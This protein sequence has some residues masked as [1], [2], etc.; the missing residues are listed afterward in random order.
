MMCVLLM[1]SGA[2]FA[3][4]KGKAQVEQTITEEE[5]IRLDYF[6]Y[7]VLDATERNEH[8]KA[9]FLLELCYTID[10]TNPTVCSL[11]GSYK[12]NL[13]GEEVALPLLR[14][15]YEG[16]PDDYWYRYAVTCYESGQRKVTMDVIK[17]MEKRQPKDLDILELHEQI[18]LHEH[19]YKKALAIRDKIDKLTGEPTVQSVFARY[20][21]YRN[22]GDQAKS[23]QVLDNYLLRNPN[24]GRMRAMRT[25]IDLTAARKNNDIESGRRLLTQQLHSADVSLQ[26]KLKL[27]KQHSEWLDYD[28]DEQLQWLQDLKEQYPFDQTIY[29]ALMEHAEEQ[30]Q[31]STALEIAQTMLAMNPTDKQL[32]EKIADLM[33]DDDN[34]TPEQVGQFIE[35]SYSILPDDPKWGYFMALRCL[36]REDYD[37]TLIVLERAITHAEE[38]MVRLQLLTLYGDI[39]GQLEQYDKAFDVY[40]EVLQLAPEHLSVLNN[41][42]WNLAIS[43]GDLKKAEKMSQRTIQKEGNN[44]TYLDTYAWILHLQGQDTLA[45]FYIKKA[46]EYA[47]GGDITTI[48]EHYEEI[49]KVLNR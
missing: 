12:Q 29:K 45:L 35:E 17:Q 43:G 10:P 16:S 38:P 19:Q 8:A 4:P 39:L 13:Y 26:N 46:L 48:Q 11:L 40:D 37:S 36:Q 44:P 15:A 23:I 32:R 6:L 27:L 9:Y 42:A 30:G 7:A 1:V 5:Q 18:L 20:E 41:Y 33:R 22:M 21:I 25:D 24:D 14:Q 47:Q 2:V 49:E 31:I 34:V 28:A 3:K